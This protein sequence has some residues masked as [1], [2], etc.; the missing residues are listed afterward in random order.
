[1]LS[2]SRL[3]DDPRLSH[4]ASEEDLTQGIIDLVGAGVAEILTLEI[5]P[6]PSKM[7][8]QPFGKIEGRG[9]PH[10]IAEVA[11]HLRLECRIGLGL[12][13]DLLQLFERR[14]QRLGDKLSPVSP[15]VSAGIGDGAPMPRVSA[16]R[17]SWLGQ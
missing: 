16:L 6:R 5:D 11:L 12:E 9:A 14:H 1:M 2:R 15:E 3:G 7:L 8:G 13:V 4:A 10:V 17:L